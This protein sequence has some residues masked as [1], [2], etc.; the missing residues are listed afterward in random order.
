MSAVDFLSVIRPKRH[1]FESSASPCGLD[2]SAYNGVL[3]PKCTDERANR[4]TDD[5]VS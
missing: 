2:L 3:A 1:Q 5:T 4:Q